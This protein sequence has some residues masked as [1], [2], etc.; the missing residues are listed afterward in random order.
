MEFNLQEYLSEMRH[1]QLKCSEKLERKLDAVVDKQQQQDTRLAIVER[2][3]KHLGW[4]GATAVAALIAFVF[5][6]F[7]KLLP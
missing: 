2:T 3:H 6:L 5:D 4:L 7:G 1:E